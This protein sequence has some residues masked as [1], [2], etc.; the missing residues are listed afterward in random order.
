MLL[1]K[2]ATHE[3]AIGGPS[4]DLPWPPARN[5]WKP[6]HITGGSS[7]GTGAAI[8]AGMLRM[9]TGSD[10]GGSI[11]GPAAWCGTGRDQ[12]DVRAR[13][14]GAGVFPLSWYAG[15]HRPSGPERGGLRDRAAGDRGP[16][17]AGPGQRRCAGAGF[18]RRAGARRERAADRRPAGVLCL[19]AADGQPRCWRAIDAAV[20]KLREAGATV[21]D[22]T[23]PRLRAVRHRRAASS[24]WRR[25]SQSIRPICARGWPTTRENTPVGSCWV[26]RSTAADYVEALRVRGA[27]W[28]RRSMR[29]WAATM[30]C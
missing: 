16:R 17:P 1:G 29:C 10:T 26:R 7:S 3:F 24:C 6:E 13:A 9:A 28:R 25:R 4:F 2:L 15:S 14:R 22:V 30:R 12:A 19:G 5:P 23:L 11:R 27:N 20:A 21:E 8:A 18:P